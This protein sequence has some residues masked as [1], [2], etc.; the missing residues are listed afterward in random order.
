MSEDKG[1]LVPQ[2]ERPVRSWKD[3]R[4]R[5][6][7]FLRSLS[8]RIPGRTTNTREEHGRDM[9][10]MMDQERDAAL[11]AGCKVVQEHADMFEGILKAKKKT[12]PS[13]FFARMRSEGP[14]L[15]EMWRMEEKF[16]R[17]TY[18]TAMNEEY[19]ED[20]LVRTTDVSNQGQTIIDFV[21]VPSDRVTV[22]S[23]VR[24]QT[25]V[26][27]TPTSDETTKSIQDEQS[28]KDWWAKN[29]PESYSPRTGLRYSTLRTGSE[30]WRIRYANL[31][32]KK[33]GDLVHCSRSLVQ[34]VE[35]GLEGANRQEILI[36]LLKGKARFRTFV[37]PDKDTVHESELTYVD[38]NYELQGSWLVPTNGKGE[39]FPYVDFVSEIA[40]EMALN[41]K[42]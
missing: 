7:R 15:T 23:T 13:A 38:T 3:T 31:I 19:L 6:G 35:H 4:D 1:D 27:R 16:L 40:K 41:A 26:F 5:F 32:Y 39:K 42:V 30:W 29:S 18:R 24:H 34:G 33:V 8:S 37:D 12:Q 36:D 14:V 25:L 22:S 20:T 11:K 17:P 10:R 21:T 9:V 28:L 2:A